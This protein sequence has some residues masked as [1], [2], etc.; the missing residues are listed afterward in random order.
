MTSQEPIYVH[1][2][3]DGLVGDGTNHI[4]AV[5]GVSTP[6]PF[7][8]GPTEGMWAVHRL[9]VMLADVGNFSSEDY[10]AISTL[11]NGLHVRVVSG[12]QTTGSVVIDLT[13]GDPINNVLGWAEH[14][15]DVEY[16][17]FGQ[18]QNYVTVRWTFSAAGRPLILDSYDSE[19]LVITVRDDLTG[20]TDHQ[21]QIQG[22][23][24]NTVNEQ[25]NTWGT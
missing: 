14:C 22:H 10:G 21:F 7:W 17:A 13:D 9:I 3:D 23:R 16:H 5:N 12:H 18:G 1:L 6:V 11:A 20:L 24:I 8:A 25:L 19:K 15:Y 2:T 4:A